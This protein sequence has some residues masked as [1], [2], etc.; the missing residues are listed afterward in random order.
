MM[1]GLFAATMRGLADATRII[2]TVCTVL[3]NPMLPV[4]AGIV[5]PVAALGSPVMPTEVGTS[6]P[7]AVMVPTEDGIAN[8]PVVIVPIGAGIVRAVGMV[9]IEAGI[10]SPAPIMGS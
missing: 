6:Y 3:R 9:P 8:P 1:Y 10:V 7:A 4:E 2:G 5:N